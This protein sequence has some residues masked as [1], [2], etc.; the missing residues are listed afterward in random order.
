VHSLVAFLIA[1]GRSKS[2]VRSIEVSTDCVCKGGL[3]LTMISFP[4]F[5]LDSWTYV[6]FGIAFLCEYT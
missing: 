2:L 1:M 5:E 3:N 6:S 4:E